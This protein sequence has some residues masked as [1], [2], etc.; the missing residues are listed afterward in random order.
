[1]AKDLMLHTIK[2]LGHDGATYMALE[3]TG[4]T[5]DSMPMDERMCLSNMAVETGAKAGLIAAD[6]ITESYLKEHGY[7]KQISFLRSD[8]DAHFY[9]SLDYDAESLEPMIACPH[10]VDNVTP[11]TEM[12]HVKIN[13][14][15]IGS[16]TGGRITDLRIA[17][18]ILKNN[19][20]SS[21]CRLL[22]SPASKEVYL[23][24]LKEG[25]LEIIVEAGGK[26]L[27]PTCGACVGLHSGILAAGENCITST[28]RNFK[29]R[30]GSYQSNLYL[31]SPASVAASAL[32]GYI[33]DP[34]K[35]LE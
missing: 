8:S 20:I 33:T 12:E 25:L 3:F 9:Q 24:A 26:I 1:M 30:M 22:V 2:Q 10:N 27:P 19:K 28:N 29:G 35:Y 31:G 18:Q 7:S 34:R 5:I 4:S 17:A 23:Q 6:T 32:A 16:C 14:A 21:D 13:Q 15:Y 11:I